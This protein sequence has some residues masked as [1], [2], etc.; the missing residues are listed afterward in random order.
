M[1]MLCV[2]KEYCSYAGV[3]A[4]VRVES[5]GSLGAGC[6]DAGWGASVGASAGA[7]GGGGG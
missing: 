7:V 1:E 5:F 4:D 2:W 3:V 6:T